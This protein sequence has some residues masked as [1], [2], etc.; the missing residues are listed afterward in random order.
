VDP[1]NDTVPET[2]VPPLH[3]EA[4]NAME[5]ND[6]DAAAKAFEAALTEAPGDKE[7]KAGLAQVQ[8]LRRLDAEG[9][10]DAIAAAEAPGAGVDAQLA[11]A[12]AQIAAGEPAAAFAR[13]IKAL[14][15][16]EPEDKET[17]R[18]RLLDLFEVVGAD[19]PAV[20]KARRDLAAALF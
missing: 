12:D 3:Q 2:P 1:A 16:A 20:A 14:R 13:L 9:K 8:L 4:Y 5:R 7:A 17:I 11:A 19:D 6:L 18:V 15:S 10:T